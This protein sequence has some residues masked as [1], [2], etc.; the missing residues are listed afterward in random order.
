MLAGRVFESAREGIIVTRP[1]G[2]IVSVNRSFTEITG[3]SAEEA[4]GRTPRI[5]KSHEHDRAFYTLMWKAIAKNGFWQGE[6]VNRRKDGSLYP[7]LLSISRIRDAD[8]Q[9]THL[10]GIFSD[11]T[12]RKADEAA[13]EAA[14]LQLR[15]SEKIR[16]ELERREAIA[17]PASLSVVSSMYS[18][19]PL[20]QSA[21]DVFAELVSRYGEILALALENLALKAENP[22][23]DQLRELADDM[24][25][26]QAGARDVAE[27]HSMTLAN[28]A[29]TVPPMK[30]KAMIEEGRFLVLELMGYLVSFYRKNYYRS[31]R[32]LDPVDAA[33]SKASRR[34]PKKES[35]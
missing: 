12:R 35:A 16:E 3:Y 10:V 28:N 14:K 6:V 19:V 18:V 20:S 9:V 32:P 21:R 4:L 7:E 29:K 27:L 31:P 24:G 30:A 17:N 25:Y 5:L 26:L 23:S 15:Q 34:R 8:A 22:V 1:D 33:N 13:L 2:V 11:L